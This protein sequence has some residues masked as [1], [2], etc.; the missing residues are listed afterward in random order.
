MFQNC[1]IIL[2]QNLQKIIISEGGKKARDKLK[3]LQKDTI[4]TFHTTAEAVIF[5]IHR[6]TPVL[7]CL[8]NKVAG[9]QVIKAK[10]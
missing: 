6:K 5:N 2:H 10:T 7:E 4:N 1:H 9:F 3:R 8:S